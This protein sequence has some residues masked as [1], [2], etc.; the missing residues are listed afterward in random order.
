MHSLSLFQK[1]TSAGSTG[2][3][4]DVVIGRIK[5]KEKLLRSIQSDMLG[6]F[7]LWQGT[8]PPCFAQNQT[9]PGLLALTREGSHQC[10]YLVKGLAF[11]GGGDS[12]ALQAGIRGWGQC[13][14]LTGNNPI[15]LNCPIWGSRQQTAR[16]TE[17]LSAGSSPD[18][19]TWPPSLG[20]SGGAGTLNF[21]VP[22][23]SPPP[24]ALGLLAGEPEP[25]P[26]LGK[27]GLHRSR[28]WPACLEERLTRFARLEEG[29]WFIVVKFFQ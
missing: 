10:L 25:P 15:T 22:C 6:L 8:C 20:M 29:V 18:T 14:T 19:T 26:P 23:W 17:K 13:L 2:G 11:S 28:S 9:C 5:L 24:G 16:H 1:L 21:G 7:Q 3:V 12:T 4:I 27:L